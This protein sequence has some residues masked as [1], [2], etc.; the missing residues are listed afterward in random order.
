VHLDRPA[1]VSPRLSREFRPELDADDCEA[2]GEQRPRR[3]SRPAADLEQRVARL[4]A[5]ERDEIVE[6]LVGIVRARR[7]V[8]FSRRVEGSAE[9][10][11]RV[12]DRSYRP[13][14]M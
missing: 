1:Q 5:G 7:V 4:E 10:L 11:A 2:A 13:P 9:R 14:E 3:L 6:E 8:P 12:L